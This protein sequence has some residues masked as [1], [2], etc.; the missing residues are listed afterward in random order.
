MEDDWLT[1]ITLSF[2]L[3]AAVVLLCWL[4]GAPS[5]TGL[6]LSSDTRRAVE[7]RNGPSLYATF[8]GHFSSGLCGEDMQLAGGVVIAVALT[9]AVAAEITATATNAMENWGVEFALGLSMNVAVVAFCWISG[10][11]P[12]NSGSTIRWYDTHHDEETDNN[13]ELDDV[14]PIILWSGGV[15]TTVGLVVAVAVMVAVAVDIA[16]ETDRNSLKLATY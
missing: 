1:E 8:P 2:G 4:R 5:S 7:S 10:W 15:E 16:S 3:N 11:R 14:D 13:D 12:E 6:R 9:A